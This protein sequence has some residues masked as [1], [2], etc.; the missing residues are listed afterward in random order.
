MSSVTVS[1][2]RRTNEITATSRAHSHTGEN[3]RSTRVPVIGLRSSFSR[4]VTANAAAVAPSRARTIRSCGHRATARKLERLEP[5]HEDERLRVL[6]AAARAVELR[7]RAD[8]ALAARMRIVAALRLVVGE[9]RDLPLDRRRR[10]RRTSSARTSSAAAGV[11][12]V[13]DVGAYVRTPA[14]GLPGRRSRRDGDRVEEHAVVAIHVRMRRVDRS[15]A[16]SRRRAPRRRGSPRRAA[17]CRGACPE[18]RDGRSPSRRARRPRAA[19]RPPCARGSP[20]RRGTASSE[21]SVTTTMRTSS[22]RSACTAIV[23]P[24][25]STSSSGCAA[26]TRTRRHPSLAPDRRARPRRSGPPRAGARP[27]RTRRPA[28]RRARRRSSP[29]ARASASSTGPRAPDDHLLVAE[30]RERAGIRPRLRAHPVVEV[31][32]ARLPVDDPVGGSCAS[33]MSSHGSDPAGCA[34][35]SARGAA[36]RARAISSTCA[37]AMRA[38]SVVAVSS[39][40]IVDRRP[41]RRSRPSPRSRRRSRRASRRCARAR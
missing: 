12:S 36:A 41:G 6:A 38:K 13:L 29:P 1:R 16:R 39:G 10:R 27:R 40:A 20:R 17:A 7:G 28:L 18:G 30:E 4:S 31:R 33:A 32:R 24:I 11:H 35:R 25:P 3:T 21:P 37:S 26:R 15:R 19:P 5:A 9:R 14:D 22:P 2:R 23:P 34:V 8:R